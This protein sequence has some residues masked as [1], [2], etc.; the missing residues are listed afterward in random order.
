MISDKKKRET[1]ILPVYLVYG[2]DTV[3]IE[4]ALDD[5]RKYF[6]GDADKDIT[7]YSAGD[8]S[9]ETV[10]CDISTVTL[11]GDRKLVIVRSC[12]DYGPGGFKQ[13]LSYIQNPF[14]QN[15][16]V[17]VFENLPRLIS[18]SLKNISE[19]CIKHY[20]EV[21]SWKLPEWIKSRVEKHGRKIQPSATGALAEIIGDNS[22]TMNMEIE[23]LIT[24]SYEKPVIGDDDVHEI[25]SSG[26]GQFW[27]LVNNIVGRN[28][29]KAMSVFQ[30]MD[31]KG[32]DAAGLI[33]VTHKK[34]LELILAKLT[35]QKKISVDD[36]S[37]ILKLNNRKDKWKIDRIFR[38]SGK[39]DLPALIGIIK[40]FPGILMSVRKNDDRTVK[41]IIEK[42][43]I[44]FCRA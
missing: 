24:Y 38:E 13:I 29:N 26:E 28:M 22:G 30:K 6:T 20:P 27:D 16:I 3:R 15:C 41:V 14:R 4:D 2:K 7:V 18:S 35:I 23:K 10:L 40:S 8:T 34:I 25:A 36:M 37:L 19:G 31:F 43:L 17:F 11:F 32:P 39:Y 33:M 44:D 5:L 21:K 1:Q 12:D 42:M 9:I